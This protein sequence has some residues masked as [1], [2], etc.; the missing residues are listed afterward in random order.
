[1]LTVAGKTMSAE[2]NPEP[3]TTSEEDDKKGEQEEGGPVVEVD[4]AAAQLQ[5]ERP[6]CLDLKMYQLK[7][8]HFDQMHALGKD[9]I[10]KGAPNFRQV[11][12]C[13]MD[14]R[15]RRPPL[16]EATCGRSAA[17]LCSAPHSRPRKV[18]GTSWSSSQRSR[19]SRQQRGKKRSC[20]STK[21]S[22]IT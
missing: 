7:I 17:F 10:V 20:R 22:G 21:S 13:M 15:S 5:P 11:D 19:S 12:Q 8:D 1:M 9:K 4:E 16:N 3:S 14:D 6:P 2:E 18:S